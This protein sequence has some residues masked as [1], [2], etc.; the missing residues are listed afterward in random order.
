MQLAS[1]LAAFGRVSS[2]YDAMLMVGLVSLFVIA[3]AVTIAIAIAIAIAIV[4]AI[5]TLIVAAVRPP[6]SHSPPCTVLQ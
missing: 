2:Q 5:S 3:I 6:A 1:W 4:I